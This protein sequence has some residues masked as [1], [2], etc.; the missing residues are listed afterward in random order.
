MWLCWVGVVVIGFG[1]CLL[2]W[3]LSRFLAIL[4]IGAIFFYT[5]L[6][7][8]SEEFSETISSDFISGSLIS[9][10]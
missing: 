6:Y 5:P 4:G 8:T 1:C 10:Y 3:D 9:Y 2:Q 7:K